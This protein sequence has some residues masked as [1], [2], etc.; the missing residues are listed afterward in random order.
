VE[1]STTPRASATITFERPATSSRLP[2]SAFDQLATG[3][4]SCG[5]TRADWQE[6]A[7]LL[8]RSATMLALLSTHA[9][10][11]P[12]AS[13]PDTLRGFSA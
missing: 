2:W 3:I 9:S 6:P 13:A 4:V 11:A 5:R 1:P 7:P 10:N 12:R 8:L